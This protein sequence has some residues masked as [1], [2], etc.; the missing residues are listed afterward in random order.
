MPKSILKLPEF[1]PKQAFAFHSTANEKLLGGAT[2]GGKTFFNKLMLIRLCS[3]VS[4]LRADIFRLHCDDVF[5][6]YMEGR[7]SF[8]EILGQWERDGLVKITQDG[9]EFLW[10][11]SGFS[12]EH[13]GSEAAK[14]KGQG[15]P[16]QIRIFD[17]A[18]QLMESR[19]RFLRGWV[20]M[21]EDHREIA[22]AELAQVFPAMSYED[23]WNYFPQIVYST[24]PIGASAGYFRRNFVKAAPRFKVFTAPLDDGGFK[25]QYIPFLVKDNPFENEDQVRQR[26]SGLGDEAMTDALLNE[27]W[28][29]PVGDFIRE[30][31]DKR[32]VVPDFIPPSHWRKLR[33]FDWGHSEPFCVLWACVSDGEPFKDHLGNERWFRRGAMIIYR[34]WYGCQEKE[35]ALGVGMKNVQIAE[36]IVERTPEPNPGGIWPTVT[37]SLPFSPR[38]GVLM[39]DEFLSHG[40][41]LSRG[42]TSRE[43][44]WKRVK[45][46]LT[47][48]D[49]DPMLFITHSCQYLR[50]Y[51]PALQRHKT[52]MED[53]VEEG[54][55]T[56]T[57]DT[58]RYI[59]MTHQLAIPK[60]PSEPSPLQV[61]IDQRLSATPKQLLKQIKQKKQ[62]NGS[63]R[64]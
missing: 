37:D 41:P 21:T 33:G 42:N 35:P 40:V 54:E 7:D 13:L 38:G 53:A 8:P 28:D 45:D 24:N 1:L 55:A 60:K 25:R 17:E 62:R 48:I 26:I 32:H 36:G 22:A 16:K 39:S 46:M 5:Q 4:N 64:Y 15:T 63:R 3:A 18:T 23:R 50:E 14:S 43:I 2:R 58:L 52:N 30:F 47:G 19:F 27:N 10:N 29:A 61:P 56:H 49:G 9:V 51:L 31:D 44:G 20:G 59:C 11:G 6:S 34:E 12:L 57:C